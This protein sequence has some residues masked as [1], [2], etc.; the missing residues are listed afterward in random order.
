MFRTLLLACGIAAASAPAMADDPAGQADHIRYFPSVAQ[1]LERLGYSEVRL[2]DAA[3][4]EMVAL[5]PE[6]RDVLLVIHPR[7]G[8]IERAIL[9]ERAGTIQTGHRG[10]HKA[11]SALPVN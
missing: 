6:G 2:V 3:T 10:R 9:L 7:N 11:A 8:S 5:D 1:S 4:R